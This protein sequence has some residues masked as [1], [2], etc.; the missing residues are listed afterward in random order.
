MTEEEE[1]VLEG[2]AEDE[3]GE[4]DEGEDE[5]GED[6]IPSVV[7]ATLGDL[8]SYLPDALRK[9]FG[10]RPIWFIREDDQELVEIFERVPE[11]PMPKG[12]AHE[13]LRGLRAFA[14]A[15]SDRLQELIGSA[16]GIVYG[17]HGDAS[18]DRVKRAFEE[19]GFVVCTGIV[20]AGQIVIPEA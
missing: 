15:E 5:D 13:L 14:E 17:F 11:D 4:D 10:D 20:R 16:E 6:E 18:L 1:D 2:E 7:I 9:S 8:G 12:R 19:D 3:A